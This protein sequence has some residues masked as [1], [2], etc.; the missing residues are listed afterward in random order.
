MYAQRIGLWQ[1]D[2]QQ[3]AL[4][5]QLTEG[6]WLGEIVFTLLEQLVRLAALSQQDETVVK[7]VALV[8]SGGVVSVAASAVSATQLARHA[9]LRSVVRNSLD[10]PIALHFLGQT[11]NTP[12]GYF[13]A[14]GALS[15]LLSLYEMWPSVLAPK[16]AIA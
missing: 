8:G 4:T 14:L 16:V 13:G 15:S 6:S 9:A 2:A 5:N 11:G 10:L 3:L 7:G 1:P 12:H